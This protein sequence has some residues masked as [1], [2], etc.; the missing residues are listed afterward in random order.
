MKNIQNKIKSC[1]KNFL[2]FLFSLGR[3]SSRLSLPGRTCAK[4][5]ALSHMRP[6]RG[7]TGTKKDIFW[8]KTWLSSWSKY[9]H[10]NSTVIKVFGIYEHNRAVLWSLDKVFRFH[11]RKKTLLLR[12]LAGDVAMWLKRP[13]G[14]C[15]PEADIRSAKHAVLTI[16]CW[17]TFEQTFVQGTEVRRAA[18][19]IETAVS[20]APRLQL[21]ATI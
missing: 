10:K 19:E 6:F 18:W 11:I 8:P 7:L 15:S 16:W 13:Q 9:F 12:L 14:W 17:K 5:P 21:G 3:L 1:W 2:I 20:G 4:L